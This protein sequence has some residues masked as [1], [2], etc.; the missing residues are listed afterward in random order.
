MKK[1]RSEFFFKV[2]RKIFLRK[3]DSHCFIRGLEIKV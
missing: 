1:V 3:T 2:L